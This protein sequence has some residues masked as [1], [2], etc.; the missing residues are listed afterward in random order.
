MFSILGFI[1]NVRE[2]EWDKPKAL[3]MT[4][5]V[6]QWETCTFLG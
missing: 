2:N 5:S 6:S 4:I 1:K 3:F